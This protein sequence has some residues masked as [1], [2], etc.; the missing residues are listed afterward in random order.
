[1]LLAYVDESYTRNRYSMV[2]LLVPDVQAISLTRALGEVVAGAAQAYE[3]VLPAE[4]HGTDLL[5]G[6]R[7]WAPIVQMRRAAVGVYHAA[8][9]AIADHEVA[10]GPIPRRPPGD[11]A[12]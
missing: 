1:M 11:D 12:V 3:V 10:T 7:G 5:H 2:A 4:L 6:N 8:F 9:L